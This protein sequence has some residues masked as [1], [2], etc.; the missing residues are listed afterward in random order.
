MNSTKNRSAIGQTPPSLGLLLNA[1][2]PFSFSVF[3]QA[4]G[5]LLDFEPF[6]TSPAQTTDYRESG[7]VEP[8]S[9]R[10]RFF[11]L[12]LDS[13]SSVG[14]ASASSSRGEVSLTFSTPPVAFR[15]RNAFDNDLLDDYFFLQTNLE[16][17]EEEVSSEVTLS[18]LSPFLAPEREYFLYLFGYGDFIG[19]DSEFVFNGETQS[20][21]SNQEPDGSG[22]TALDRFCKFRFTTGS[23][24]DDSLNFLWRF[25]PHFQEPRYT[26]GR[27]F[28][29]FNGLAIVPVPMQSSP[30]NTIEIS[31]VEPLSSGG[32]QFLLSWPS[33]AE[34]RYLFE[35]LIT[36]RQN[37]TS[38]GT[39]ETAHYSDGTVTRRLVY[40]P[41]SKDLVRI[42]EASEPQP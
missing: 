38:F 33:D 8:F 24:V 23:T 21:V 14:P 25:G 40:S 3:L 20:P 2:I 28:A 35:F 1:I 26:S 29:A 31:N 30:L 15:A 22:G 11:T 27:T 32:Y 18:G 4:E 42:I 17:E 13:A 16:A 12:R 7:L 6:A 34:G 39:Q 5:L 10:A 37:R 19:Q 36:R 9:R 41:F